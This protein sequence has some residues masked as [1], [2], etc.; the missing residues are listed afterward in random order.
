[1]IHKLPLIALLLIAFAMPA[2]LLAEKT[3]P[4]E[5]VQ[6]KDET[7]SKETPAQDNPNKQESVEAKEQQKQ[8]KPGDQADQNKPADQPPA[9]PAEAKKA[10]FE[11]QKDAVKAKL[12][13]DKFSEPMNDVLKDLLA[14]AMVGW[15][16]NGKWPRDKADYAASRPDIKLDNKELIQ[17]MTMKIHASAMLD[18]YVR[19]Q[20]ASFEPDLSILTPAQRLEYVR[21]MP[22]VLREPEPRVKEMNKAIRVYIERVK[23]AAKSGQPTYHVSGAS[24]M[25]IGPAPGGIG[26]QSLRVPVHQAYFM[27]FDGDPI[28]FQP[29]LSVLNTGTSLTV[30]GT[31]SADGRYVTL[32]VQSLNSTLSQIREFSTAAATASRN[33]RDDVVADLPREG[34][35]RLAGLM[36]DLQNRLAVGHRSADEVA[37][38][39][40]EE[41]KALRSD[42]SLTK[43]TRDQLIDLLRDL[44]RERSQIITGVTGS[45]SKGFTAKTETIEL[46]NSDYNA[47]NAYLRGRE[48]RGQ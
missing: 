24:A 6:G 18:G 37:K 33:L 5:S 13:L 28:G 9:N 20:L 16:V 12:K 30:G 43:A 1:M 10:R 29:T 46:S 23:A 41:A 44:Q 22:R 45:V 3:G 17:V 25:S 31:V 47:M 27:D 36:L 15:T 32:T 2:V 8:D 26:F 4:D 39:A 48:Y 11:Q 21:Q 42:P 40:V 38:K 14:E 35:L 34:G 19:W 7:A